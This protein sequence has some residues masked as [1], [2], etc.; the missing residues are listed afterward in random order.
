LTSIQSARHHH[1]PSD[2]HSDISQNYDARIQHQDIPKQPSVSQIDLAG[3]GL[4]IDKSEQVILPDGKPVLLFQAMDDG[5]LVQIRGTNAEN[6]IFTS[7][8]EKPGPSGYK[9]GPSG[10]QSRRKRTA[11]GPYPEGVKNPPVKTQCYDQYSPSPKVIDQDRTA[12]HKRRQNMKVAF[13]HLEKL[14]IDRSDSP[15][16]SGKMS[17]ALI[18]KKARDHINQCHMDRKSVQ[19]DISL[20]RRDC[21][22]LHQQILASQDKMPETGIPLSKPRTDKIQKEFLE[23]VAQRTDE[24]PKFY[25]FAKV[26]SKL[27]ESYTSVVSASDTGRLQST[28][29][30]WLDTHCK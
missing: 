15:I 1:L 13:D 30:Q 17:K 10:Y 14:L 16:S 20:H 25:P 26:M 8:D 12:E 3:M 21:E 22:I 28:C 18:L 23:Y 6:V 7:N 27:F 29:A 19:K 4:N 11:E 2:Q 24:N 5:S 9:T